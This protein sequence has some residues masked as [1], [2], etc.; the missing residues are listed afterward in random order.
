MPRSEQP[1]RHARWCRRYA[2]RQL[3]LVYP[4]LIH[5][6]PTMPP[7]NRTAR[8]DMLRRV[9]SPP[10]HAFLKGARGRSRT[11][12]PPPR[13]RR[14]PSPYAAATSRC[15]AKASAAY[16]TFIRAARQSVLA[17]CY[18][19]EG[20]G[21]TQLSH[22]DCSARNTGR[23]WWWRQRQALQVAAS[24]IRPVL[25]RLPVVT[26]TMRNCPEWMPFRR[27]SHRRRPALP[28]TTSGFTEP[29]RRK[30]LPR[31]QRSARRF[32]ATL[33]H[34]P[35]RCFTSVTMPSNPHRANIR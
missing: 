35:F 2:P 14:R 31:R 19:R 5:H 18:A 3:P 6:R 34:P 1:R 26:D 10:D 8:P 12:L 22:P 30:A 25:P 28:S 4:G 20:A 29:A 15:A 17:W 16:A 27:Q 11:V 13:C 9:T 7:G 21:F 23:Q 33:V 24:S 32:S